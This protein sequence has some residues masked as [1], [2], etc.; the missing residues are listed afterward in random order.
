MI[1][2]ENLHSLYLWETDISLADFYMRPVHR[3]QIPMWRTAQFA[4]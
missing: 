4:P 2:I 1:E 3:L